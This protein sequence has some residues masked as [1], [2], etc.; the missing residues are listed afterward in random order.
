VSLTFGTGPWAIDGC[1]SSSAGGCYRTQH[2]V[3]TAEQRVEFIRLWAA[4]AAMPRCEP[5][6][7]APGDPAY[8]IH[9]PG[10][11]YDGHLPA[12]LAGLPTRTSGVCTADARLAWW[13]A[14]RLGA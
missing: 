7:F 4:V 13:L 9:T 12:A 1:V 8:T 14:Q 2:V 3:L 10:A 5:S 11:D 6:A